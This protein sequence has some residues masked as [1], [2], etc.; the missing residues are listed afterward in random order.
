MKYNVNTTALNQEVQR[1][2]KQ[3]RIFKY[4]FFSDE[5]SKIDLAHFE[6]SKREGKFGKKTLDKLELMGVQIDRILVDEPQT[7]T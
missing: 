7:V 1:I 3:K 4:Q 2:M 5:Y 6:R